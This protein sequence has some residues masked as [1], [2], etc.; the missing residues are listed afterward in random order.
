[1]DKR[2]RDDIRQRPRFV[3][4]SPPALALD[5]GPSTT[6]VLRLRWRL[7]RLARVGRRCLVPTS[8]WK[9][10]LGG[11]LAREVRYGAFL[12]HGPLGCH[13]TARFE[14][15]GWDVPV[16]LPHER[17]DCRRVAEYTAGRGQ[18]TTRGA[19]TRPRYF[20]V[21]DGPGSTSGT[22]TP[23]P[24]GLT[25]ADWD[26]VAVIVSPMASITTSMRSRTFRVDDRQ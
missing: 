24:S 16:K 26:S 20:R 7:L 8:R 10:S 22:A 5:S 13:S 17:G 12:H 4:V 25:S 2:G 9:A 21:P 6:A 15:R 18:L 14:S 11:S 3:R 1:M 19:C 23:S